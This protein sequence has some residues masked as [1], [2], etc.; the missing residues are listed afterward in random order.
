MAL[1]SKLQKYS[2]TKVTLKLGFSSSSCNFSINILYVHPL[3]SITGNNSTLHRPYIKSLHR[4]CYSIPE[5]KPE[6]N[7]TLVLEYY[8]NFEFSTT[9]I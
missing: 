1:K 4:E 5:R 2:K 8:C 9:F 3:L 7:V 6:F